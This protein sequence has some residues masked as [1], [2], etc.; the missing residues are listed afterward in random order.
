MQFTLRCKGTILF[1][2]LIYAAL[3]IFAEKRVLGPSDCVQVKYIVQDGENYLY[4]PIK[5][6]PQG[7]RVAYMVK[8]PNLAQDRDDFA[9]Y[10]KDLHDGVL[11]GGALVFAGEALSH[12]EW[13]NDGNHVV[14]LARVDGV[15]S[16]VEIDVQRGARRTL[17]HANKD[18]VEYSIDGGGQTLVYA[19]VAGAPDTK[20]SPA[21]AP[22]EISKGYH[23]YIEVPERKTGPYTRS[24]LVTHRTPTGDWTRPEAMSV[25]DPFTDKGVQPV[26]LAG[27][28]SLS[29][30]GNRLLF[31]YA[32]ENVPEE[33]KDNPWVSSALKSPAPRM[34]TVL[35]DLRTK[36]TTVPLKTLWTSSIPMWSR[37]SRSFLINAHSPVGSKWVQEDIRNHRTA[38]GDANLFWVEPDTGTVEEVVA[39]VVN[40]HELPLAWT[41]AGDVIV[42]VSGNAVATFRRDNRSWREV[43]RFDI[44][45]K[46]FHRYSPLTSTGAAVLIGVHQT[47][48]TPPDLFI[49]D[50]KG[51][52]V[53]MLTKVNPQ[54]DEVTL[55]S[56][57]KV[58]WQTSGGVEM[59]GFLFLPPGYVPGKRYPLVIQ[60][61]GNQGWFACDSGFNHDPAF[62]P[63]PIANAGMMYLIRTVL[64][65]FKQ[66][67]D[68]AHY[69]KQY[70]GGLG[71][72]F[73]LMDSW[74]S[75]I[76]A[77]DKQ[78]LIDPTKVGIIGFSRTG[79]HVETYL[80]HSKFRFA[81]ATAADNIQ[82]SFGE[83]FL[84]NYERHMRDYDSLYGGPPYGATLANW[85]TYSVSFNLDKI[86]TPLLMEQMGYGVQDDTP[87]KVP[88]ELATRYEVYAGLT[89]LGK[90]VELYY[91]PSDV[92]T[93][94][95][96]VARLATIQRNLDWYRFWLQDYERPDPEDSGQYVRWR[97]LR[98]LHKADLLKKERTS[99]NAASAQGIVVNGE[100]AH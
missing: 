44:P 92:H 68:T 28:L 40:H 96:P 5:V 85:L 71:E 66:E 62:A 45:L 70:P 77:L 16:L 8:S 67:D 83:Y 46:D 1:V 49:Y 43:S 98:E 89:H 90:P 9:L 99:E 48:V 84:L 34:L 56:I 51:D 17:F 26:P 7:T 91:Y 6:N 94:D 59:S 27:R 18:I 86:H 20:S 97:A 57:K 24:L 95:S 36:E 15:I 3:P 21:P 63:Q 93:P 30:D 42:H 79:W 55:A 37:D 64:E 74:E 4:G 22:G 50:P 87:G 47:P 58:R 69:P 14:A 65:N 2:A 11:D 35:Y 80:V 81:A 82:Y 33:W 52:G 100:R 41:Q 10:V 23:V 12:I 76:H 54:L 31:S 72:A 13:L 25:V 39:Y 19:V 32:V 75:A 73:F 88:I 60:T 29:P 53:H 61:K 78:G 38:G